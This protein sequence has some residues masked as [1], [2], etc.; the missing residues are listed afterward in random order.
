LHRT[1]KGATKPNAE[2]IVKCSEAKPDSPDGKMWA[3]AIKTVEETGAAAVQR[4]AGDVMDYSTHVD[5]VA[6]D[7]EE[8]KAAEANDPVVANGSPWCE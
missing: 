4:A 6:T 7:I 5:P 8:E 3:A 2:E 1:K